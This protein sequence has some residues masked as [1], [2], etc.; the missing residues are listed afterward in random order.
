MKTRIHAIIK[1]K[2]QGVFFRAFVKKLAGSIGATG[3]VKNN[4][5]GTVEV[6]AEAEKALLQKLLDKCKQGNAWSK[7]EVINAKWK[8]PTGEFREFEIRP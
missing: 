7:V 3:W 4:P 5:D 6:V 1:G 8:K 2:V